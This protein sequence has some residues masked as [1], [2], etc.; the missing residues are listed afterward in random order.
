MELAH[1]AGADALP[2]QSAQLASAVAS[3]KK[4]L[5]ANFAQPRSPSPAE[6]E[7]HPGCRKDQKSAQHHALSAP[8]IGRADG[9]L[10]IR[11]DYWSGPLDW[12]GNVPTSSQTPNIFKYLQI[13]LSFLANTSCGFS[14]PLIQPSLGPCSR[15]PPNRIPPP[16]SP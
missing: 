8:V 13:L 15:P 1:P 3:T 6:S 16:L 2:P 4:S 10:R 11:P 7:C 5:L 9:R 14:L 12:R